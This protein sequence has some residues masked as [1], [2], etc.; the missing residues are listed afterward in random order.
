MSDKKWNNVTV[1]NLNANGTNITKLLPKQ[2]PK[3]IP[4]LIPYIFLKIFKGGDGVL[5]AY[6]LL[7]LS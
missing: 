4:K 6:R 7:H 5:G 1:Q 3:R 2:I